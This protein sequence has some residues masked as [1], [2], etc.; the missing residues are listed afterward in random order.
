MANPDGTVQDGPAAARPQEAR[1]VRPALR[2]DALG[3][4]L[5]VTICKKT[6]G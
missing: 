1:R 2:V 5:R 4:L 6:S 3:R